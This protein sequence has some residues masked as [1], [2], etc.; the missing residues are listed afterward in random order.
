MAEEVLMLSGERREFNNPQSNPS[1]LLQHHGTQ[2][3]AMLRPA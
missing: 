1:L 3:L 2:A